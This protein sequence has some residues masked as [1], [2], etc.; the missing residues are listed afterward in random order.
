MIETATRPPGDP[1]DLSLAKSFRRVGWVG[2]WVQIVIGA[3]PLTVGAGL[4][5]FNRNVVL[6][7]GRF[8]L[9]G[10]LAI[11]GLLI[12]VFTTLWFLRYARLGKRLEQGAEAPSQRRLSRIVWTGLTASS[13][14]ILFSTIVMVVEVT[15]LLI[16]FLE[17]PQAGLPVIQTTTGDGGASWISA[18]DMVSLMAL[19]LTVAAE[20]IVLVLGLW[21]LH[22]VLLRAHR[23]AG[24]PEAAGAG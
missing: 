7:G 24:A 4:F 11:A 16:N 12:L 22:R 23:A 13:I 18:L 8:D 21:L 3:V 14:G 6:P 15:Y 20:I 1:A 19:I 5:L 2:F 10:Y 9:V 17:A